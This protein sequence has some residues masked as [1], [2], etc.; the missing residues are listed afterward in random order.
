MEQEEHW[1][2]LKKKLFGFGSSFYIIA[3]HTFNVFC[4][5]FVVSYISN[6]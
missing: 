4:V 3:L 1:K 6:G 5:V 2:R